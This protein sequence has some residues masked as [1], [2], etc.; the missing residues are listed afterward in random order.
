[1]GTYDGNILADTK[2]SLGVAA[3]VGPFD[4]E[5][6][7]HIN[8]ALA[9]LNQLGIGPVAGFAVDDGSEIWENF[10]S[11]DLKLGSI[12]TYVHLRVKQI[13]DPPANS[14]TQT[15]LKDQIEKLEFRLN[16][17][18]EYQIPNAYLEEE[19]VLDGGVV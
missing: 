17:A 11:D 1:M 10:V 3:E 4:T 8:S 14:W 12:K 18:R 16:T 7:M 19:N 6:K 15:A 13:F 2:E 5:I 9:D